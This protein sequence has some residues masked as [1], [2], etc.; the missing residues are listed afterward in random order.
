MFLYFIL[1]DKFH[2]TY[3]PVMSDCVSFASLE[4]K[5]LKIVFTHLPS[6][7][8][9]KEDGGHQVQADLTAESRYADE[10]RDK[11]SRTY[12]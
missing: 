6:V 2:W 12:T 9:S 7:S 10:E 4:K 5:S 3:L 8:K 11:F 1:F